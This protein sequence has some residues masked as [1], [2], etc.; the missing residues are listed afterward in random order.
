MK[1]VKVLPCQHNTYGAEIVVGVLDMMRANS[2]PFP[3]QPVESY[4]VLKDDVT[5]YGDYTH[6]LSTEDGKTYLAEV[7]ENE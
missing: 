7:E 6:L 5:G 2:H 4:Q 1:I 3:I